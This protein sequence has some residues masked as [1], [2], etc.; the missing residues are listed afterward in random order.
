MDYKVIFSL[1]A[2]NDLETIVRYVAL[3]NTEIA[4]RLGENLLNKAKELEKFPLRGQIVPE[5]NQ[6]NLR[7]LILKPYRICL[8]Q[9]NRD[10]QR[11]AEI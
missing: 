9:K 5:F 7:Q 3:D 4:R 10:S 11:S 8:G 2:V 6:A 1:K